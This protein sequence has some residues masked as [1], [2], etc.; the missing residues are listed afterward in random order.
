LRYEAV[1]GG[2]S[3]FSLRLS[4]GQALLNEKL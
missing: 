3:R 1:L 4:D 2:G